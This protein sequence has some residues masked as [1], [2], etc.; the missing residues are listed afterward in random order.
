MSR[1]R[2]DPLRALSDDERR[3]LERLSRS[4][5]APAAQA[6]RAT[7]LLA[8]ADGRSYLTAARRAGRRDGDAVAAWVARF[9]RE[10][11]AAVRPAHGGGRP[12]RYADAQQRRILAEAAR[13]PD[14][15]RDGTATW[16]LGT[17]R[18]ALRH[19]EDGL[20]TVSTY[21]IWRTLREAGLGRQRSRTWC[22]TGTVV[23]RRRHGGAVPVTDE[24]AAAKKVDRAGLRAR[25]AGRPGG[26]V[27]GRGRAVPGRPAPRRRPVERPAIRPHEYVRGG[28]TKILTLF[29][30][31]TGEARVRP[32][33][34]GTNAVLHGRLKQALAATVAALPAATEPSDPAAARALWEAWQQGLAVRFTLP[35][36]PPPLRILPVWD[37]LAGHETPE[38]VL[39]LCRHGIMPLYTPL[40]GSW[41]NMAE[42]IR[43]ILKRRALGGQQPRSPAEIGA[44]FEQTAGNWNRA[45]HAVRVA[46]QAPPTATPAH[47]RCS[48]GR[49][50]SGCYAPSPAASTDGAARIPKSEPTDP[51]GSSILRSK[52]L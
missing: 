19:A 36:R 51:L 39:W 43:R 41:L 21:T 38:M 22:V 33:T 9:N 30:P 3:A 49:W 47:R 34:R 48:P 16:G 44:W 7:A 4:R 17:L 35:E 50:L 5:H 23:R 42:S 2:T 11:L 29:H 37:N 20:P 27:R 24:D 14:R 52:V 1:R 45:A 12:G 46:R 6:A 8:V 28:T 40:G 15:E 25:P 31:A 32:A 10:G 13:V 26:L 18:G